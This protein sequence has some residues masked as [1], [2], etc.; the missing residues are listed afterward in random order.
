MYVLED[1]S[2]APLLHDLDRHSRPQVVFI[3]HNEQSKK[4]NI[5]AEAEKKLHLDEVNSSIWGR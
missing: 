3:M 2:E 4:D 5:P 1:Y